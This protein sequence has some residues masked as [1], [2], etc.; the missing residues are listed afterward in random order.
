MHQPVE[1]RRDDDR[2]AQH[3]RPILQGAVGGDDGGRM[4]IPA[5]QHFGEFV[6]RLGGQFA[7]EQII[8]QQEVDGLEVLTIRA[9]PSQ[10][11]RFRQLFDELMRFA[12]EHLEAAL[13][14]EQGE[15]LGAVTFP[16]ARWAKAKN[17]FF[18]RDEVQRAQLMDLPFRHSRVVG[19]V[20]G[21]EVFPFAQARVCEAP[22]QQPGVAAMT[23][24]RPLS[25][26]VR[27]PC[28]KYR[29]PS[30][31][32]WSDGCSSRNSSSTWRFFRP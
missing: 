24:T 27:T 2:V 16:G 20:E 12:V 8:D 6:T 1:E 21:L 5:H 25:S 30:R 31:G 19:P 28:V 15:R 3:A 26:T 18:R 7:Q 13:H 14:G 9:D 32:G 23:C 22:L 29:K 4:V 11:A 17:V 10:L